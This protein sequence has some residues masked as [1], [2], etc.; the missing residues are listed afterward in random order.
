M[1]PNCARKVGDACRSF[2]KK[3]PKDE[4]RGALE[5]IPK[6][7]RCCPDCASVIDAALLGINDIDECLDLLLETGFSAKGWTDKQGDRAMSLFSSPNSFPKILAMGFEMSS[8]L[9]VS[10][11]KESISR[12]L[13]R[14]AFPGSVVAPLLSAGFPASFRWEDGKTPLH[15]LLAAYASNARARMLPAKEEEFKSAISLVLL[16]GADPSA[17]DNNGRSPLSQL[18][19]RERSLVENMI[20][21][22]GRGGDEAVVR[23]APRRQAI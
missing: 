5:R 4:R 11:K 9:N 2:C 22:F 14:T 20:M 19:V 10:S 16:G 15:F 21:K 18:E 17:T 6:Y 7:A 8:L 3:T 12:R 13:W 23:K 1:S